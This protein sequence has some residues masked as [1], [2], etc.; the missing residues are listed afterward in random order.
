[1]PCQRGSVKRVVRDD[2]PEDR[3]G[4]HLISGAGAGLSTH[5]E[6]AQRAAPRNGRACEGVSGSRS[7]HPA[8]R[9][10]GGCEALTGIAR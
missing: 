7:P 3:I 2:G 4:R 6:I 8:E 5:E 1:M 10:E 9:V